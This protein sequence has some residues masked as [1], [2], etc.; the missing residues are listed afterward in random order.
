MGTSIGSKGPALTATTYMPTSFGYSTTN[1][2][3]FKDFKLI[4][5]ADR[6]KQ[7]SPDKRPTLVAAAPKH[8][9]TTNQKQLVG[10][11]KR[12]C[13]VDQIPYP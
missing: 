3:A 4:P 5:A 10:L 1:Q 12:S 2:E 7:Y 13:L 11:P 6:A 9:T 8:F